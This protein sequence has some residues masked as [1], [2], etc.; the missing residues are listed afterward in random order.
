MPA[1]KSRAGSVRAPRDSP[2]QQQEEAEPP[3]EALAHPQGVVV[4]E[5]GG[6]GVGVERREGKE[7]QQQ[8]DQG[9]RREQGGERGHGA[10][11]EGPRLRIAEV[12][13]GGPQ[14][15]QQKEVA[16]VEEE[17][18][19]PGRQVQHRQQG[20]DRHQPGVAEA[21]EHDQ[22]QQQGRPEGDLE[23][24]EL[25]TSPRSR[26]QRV[27]GLGAGP[28]GGVAAGRGSAV[29]AGILLP[30]RRRAQAAVQRRVGARWSVPLPASAH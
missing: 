17:P 2:P 12:Q 28:G 11:Q 18:P 8:G 14:G 1:V 6:E 7:A 4:A 30:M 5:I 19:R 27:Q 26:G 21:D 25:P 13:E 16:L 9:G 15:D 3:G 10:R 23:A 29:G 20:R 24:G 22:V